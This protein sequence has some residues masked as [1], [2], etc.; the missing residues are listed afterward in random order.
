MSSQPVQFGV[1][2][3]IFACPG[4]Q[5]F[6]TPGFGELD[7]ADG[8]AIWRGRPRSSATTRSGSPIT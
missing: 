1:C 2:L 4:I 8:P 3:P 7:P 5:L 6:R